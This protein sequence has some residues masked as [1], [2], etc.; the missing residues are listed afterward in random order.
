MA[1]VDGDATVK[2]LYIADH[3][4]ELRPENENTGRSPSARK[5]ILADRWAR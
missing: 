5:P 2:R 4:I 3:R 1:L